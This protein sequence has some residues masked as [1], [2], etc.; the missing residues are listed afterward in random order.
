MINAFK[1]ILILLLMALTVRAF[2]AAQ[3][4]AD[5]VRLVH[6][7]DSVQVVMDFYFPDSAVGKRD[8]L[9]LIPRLKYGNNVKDLPS[10]GVYGRI[11]YYY[12]VRSGL[13]LFQDE[14]DIMYR[15]K[16]IHYMEQKVH[17]AR[18]IQAREWMDSAAV[19]L[20]YMRYT[21][22]GDVMDENAW[23]V[24]E[25]KKR[26]APTTAVNS[27][28][29]HFEKKGVMHIDFILDSITVRPDYHENWR[30]L[31]K[32][33]RDLDSVL[34]DQRFKIDTV[35]IHGYASPE[36]PY[37]HNVW[38]AKNRAL[39]LKSYIA[40]HFD[41]DTAIIDS[42][43]TPEDWAGLRRYVDASNLPH[44]QEI[45][46][47][48]DD[49]VSRPDPDKRLRYIRTRYK[50]DFADIFDNSLPYLRHS[51]YT[52]HYSWDEQKLLPNRQ[53]PTT[54]AGAR[55]ER[56]GPQMPYSQL[57]VLRP[58]AAIK[59]NLLFDMALWP[60]VELEVPFGHDAKYSLMANWGSPWYVWHHNSRAY[61]ILNLGL[62]VR[63]WWGDCDGCRP[64]LTGWFAGIYGAGGKY[65]LE[66]NSVGNQGEYL[67]FG[68]SLGY[69]WLL[70]DN[71]N[72]EV[73]GT[74]GV[75]FGKRRFYRGEFN[76]TH[77]IWYHFGNI[78]YVGPTQLKVSLVW[79]IPRKWF[80]LDKEKKGGAQ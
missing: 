78:F 31:D 24:V 28:T 9:L 57:P 15:A 29:E 20:V 76:D 55:Q 18:T 51:D 62:E 74:A 71:L 41:L 46:D 40:D 75:L 59:T 72:L 36:G 19:E 35:T 37:K 22:C 77:L 6:Y 3:L 65:D 45:L 7:K 11:P 54:S 44:R 17:Y 42:R 68:P 2:G 5:G 27:I 69:S 14:S 80:G 43:Y 34:N 63:R 61:E 53:R 25:A 4:S 73:S 26:I 12:A 79:L 32:L 38:L 39:A 60:N 48:I 70:R 52:I 66:W 1:Y 67:S 50:K 21:C 47:V 8:V 23:Q 16:D 13:H 56:I 58:L 10:V 64:V 49:T 30:E 33:R